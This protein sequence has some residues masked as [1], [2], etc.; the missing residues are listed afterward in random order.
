MGVPDHRHQGLEIQGKGGVVHR[1]EAALDL[2]LFRQQDLLGGIGKQIGVVLLQGLIQGI[3]VLPAL[4]GGVLSG[5]IGRDRQYHQQSKKQGNSA[6]HP[7]NSFY[8]MLLL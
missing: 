7:I 3:Q 4:G 8:Q 2:R 5:G 1:G 6:S